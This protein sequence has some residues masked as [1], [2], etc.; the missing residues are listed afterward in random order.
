MSAKTIN[1]KKDLGYVKDSLPEDDGTLSLDKGKILRKEMSRINQ[2]KLIRPGKTEDAQ[3]PKKSEHKE[4]EN[5]DWVMSEKEKKS[6]YILIG[7]IIAIIL[8]GAGFFLIPKLFHTE[9]NIV[10][11][12]YTYNQFKFEKRYG[13]WFT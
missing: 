10:E 3:S 7:V 5:Q 12:S 1:A 9:P 13:T 11:E 6:S 2:E 4:I 8:I